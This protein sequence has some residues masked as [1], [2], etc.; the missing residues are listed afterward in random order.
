M[1]QNVGIPWSLNSPQCRVGH[2]SDL[3]DKNKTA[4]FSYRAAAR[5]CSLQKVPENL[6]CSLGYHSGTKRTLRRPSE[7]EGASSVVMT[8]DCR[9]FSLTD[10]PELVSVTMPINKCVLPR[11]GYYFPISK[12]VACLELNLSA[13]TEAA[14]CRPSEFQ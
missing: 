8:P 14:S 1:A 7:I 3:E 11:S 6:C 13:T 10:W 9:S 12:F 5:A 4:T 2:R